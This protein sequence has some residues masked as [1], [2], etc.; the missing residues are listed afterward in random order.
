MNEKGLILVVEDHG[1]T[2]ELLQFV[3]E[4]NGFRVLTAPDGQAALDLLTR[5]TPDLVLTDL[6]MPGMEGV[7][8]I[9]RLRQ[10]PA[11]ARTPVI[12]MS[13]NHG[14]RLEEALEMGA[15]SSLCKPL[16]LNSL[17]EEITR[18]VRRPVESHSHARMP[19]QI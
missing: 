3:L 16:D 4:F 8:F 18:F 15:T 11:F 13:A 17:L 1:D 14:R 5:Q 6:M 2:R 10:R 7:E 9:R 19:R 12:I